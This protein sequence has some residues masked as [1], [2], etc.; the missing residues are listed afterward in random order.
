MRWNGWWRR[1]S[2]QLSAEAGD[3][4]RRTDKGDRPED[5]GNHKRGDRAV[6][7]TEQTAHQNGKGRSASRR[8]RGICVNKK[9]ASPAP[10]VHKDFGEGAQSRPVDRAAPV[11]CER[12]P[13]PLSGPSSA[14]VSLVLFSDF[15]CSYCGD[16]RDTLKEVVKNYG[17]KVR[18][19]FRQLP[20]T[21]IH[22]FAQKAAEASLCAATQGI[23]GKCTTCCSRIRRKT[24]AKKTS[25]RRP[26]NSA[27]TPPPSINALTES[28][29]RSGAG[30][31]PRRGRRRSR[32]DPRTVR[33]RQ[34]FERESPLRGT[35]RESST[36]S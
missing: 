23:S 12:L 20:L 21:S 4:Q 26:V 35:S 36:K 17:E 30:G 24:S 9:R 14:P 33:Q 6:L 19:V 31:H 5:A 22:P 2:W 1:S 15:Q 13:T 8:S 27:S 3:L 16:M 11:W 25:K 29:Y 28:G 32:G 10:G 7:R 18:L 34:V